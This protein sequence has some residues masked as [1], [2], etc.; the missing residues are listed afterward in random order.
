[1]IWRQDCIE[2]E[3]LGHR[4]GS[5]RCGQVSLTGGEGDKD[6]TYDNPMSI[7]VRPIC[8][9]VSK[10]WLG[11]AN[12]DIVAVGGPARLTTTDQLKFF[13]PLPASSQWLSVTNKFPQ[14]FGSITHPAVS[15]WVNGSCNC[16]QEKCVAMLTADHASWQ[17]L[18]QL[19]TDCFLL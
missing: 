3:T 2:A 10:Y 16:L 15:G 17:H 1:M 11:R 4:G 12:I 5:R 19:S 8:R 6:S 9:V 18:F 14:A 7:R 13:N